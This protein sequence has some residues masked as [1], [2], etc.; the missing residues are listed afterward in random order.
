MTREFLSTEVMRV[1]FLVAK[2]WGYMNPDFFFG[3]KNGALSLF[4]VSFHLQH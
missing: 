3:G 1:N 4:S 2:Y